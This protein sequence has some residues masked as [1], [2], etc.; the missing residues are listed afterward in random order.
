MFY[1]IEN[2]W[3]YAKN[4]CS[5]LCTLVSNY[6][7]SVFNYLYIYVVYVPPLKIYIYIQFYYNRKHTAVYSFY[8]IPDKL[9]WV[10]DWF[11]RLLKISPY[12]QWCCWKR[13]SNIQNLRFQ[14]FIE[15]IVLLPS[16]TQLCCLFCKMKDAGYY[17][18][19]TFW[20]MQTMAIV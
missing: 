14:C 8:K 10:I 20:K 7:D 6:F 17:N 19:S 4:V 15:F 13:I 1:Q 2:S 5:E 18:A 3:K 11:I 9:N 16:L 12:T